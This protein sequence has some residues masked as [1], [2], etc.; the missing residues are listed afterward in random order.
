[1]TATGGVVKVVKSNDMREPSKEQLLAAGVL[2]NWNKDKDLSATEV[3]LESQRRTWH[4]DKV[5]TKK[6]KPHGVG[7]PASRQ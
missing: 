1:M 2:P 5:S 3:L 6:P 4:S 7:G